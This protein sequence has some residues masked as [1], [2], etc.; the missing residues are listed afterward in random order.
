MAACRQYPL[1]YPASSS[2]WPGLAVRTT[3]SLPLAYARPIHVFAR[4]EFV[5]TWMPGT[6]PGMTNGARQLRGADM[7][8]GPRPMAFF[9][10]SVPM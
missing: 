10:F 5:K 9:G 8:G 3:A 4:D 7:V 6:R 1:K 2:S